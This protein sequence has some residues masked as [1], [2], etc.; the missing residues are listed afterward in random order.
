[1]K[2]E[3]DIGSIT[4][5]PV[6]RVVKIFA[7]AIVYIGNFIMWLMSHISIMFNIMASPLIKYHMDK[8]FF[9]GSVR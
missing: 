6:G 7:D 2:V 3:T 1:M 8:L 4:A 9:K 5:S